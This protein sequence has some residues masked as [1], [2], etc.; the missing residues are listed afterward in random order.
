MSAS[1]HFAHSFVG[2]RQGALALILYIGFFSEFIR[3]NCLLLDIFSWFL[4]FFFSKFI[5]KVSISVYFRLSIENLMQK[6]C[7]NKKNIN[8]FPAHINKKNEIYSKI[9]AKINKNSVVKSTTTTQNSG[10]KWASSQ[11]S[12]KNLPMSWLQFLPPTGRELQF[13]SNYKLIY[14]ALKAL[15]LQL[16]QQLSRQLVRRSARGFQLSGNRLLPGNMEGRRQQR[17]LGSHV[18]IRAQSEKRILE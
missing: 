4:K 16:F 3:D 18:S 2:V 6:S 10:N 11:R 8:L 9:H 15:N 13:F 12:P 5:R 17:Q 1:L 7:W 14:V